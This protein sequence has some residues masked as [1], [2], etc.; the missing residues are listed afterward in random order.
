[1]AK[2]V[3]LAFVIT[4][5]VDFIA[6]LFFIL[7]SP[8]R[9]LS[10]YRSVICIVLLAGV[11]LVLWVAAIFKRFGTGIDSLK[12]FAGNL[13]TGSFLYQDIEYIVLVTL[14]GT[15]VTFV[16]SFYLRRLIYDSQPEISRLQE[17]LMII[18]VLMCAG[19]LCTGFEYADYSKGQLKFSLLHGDGSLVPEGETF[20]TEDFIRLKNTGSNTLDLDDMFLSDKP[21]NLDLLSL[22]GNVIPAGEELTI[23][24]DVTSPFGLGAGETV[25]LSDKSGRVYD[26]A[27]YEPEPEVVYEEPLFSKVSGFYDDEF[28]LTLSYKEEAGGKDETGNAPKIYYTIDGSEPTMESIPYDQPIRIYDRKGEPAPCNMAQR[29]VFDYMYYQPDDQDIDRAFVVK[30]AVFDEAGNRSN[31]ST[32]VYFVGYPGYKNRKVISIT[33][34]YTDLFGD[35]G[36]CVTGPQYDMWYAGGQNGEEPQVNFR[37]SGRLWE[38]EGSIQFFNNGSFIGEQN[39]GIR[40]FGGTSRDFAKKRFSIYSR[41]SYSGSDS[42][43]MDIFGNGRPVHSIALRDGA[44]DAVLQEL[45]SGRDVAS[46]QHTKVSVFLN[47]EFWFNTFA[48]EKYSPAYF[49]EHKGISEDNIIIVKEGLIDTGKPEDEVLY[50][51]IYEYLGEH[52]LADPANYYEFCTMIDVQSY[53][54]YLCATI[55]GCNLDQNEVINRQMYRARTPIEYGENDGRWRWSLYDMDFLDGLFGALDYFEVSNAYEINSFKDRQSDEAV[56]I[57]EQTLFKALMQNAEFRDQFVA[58]FEDMVDTDYS[59]DNVD[60]VLDKYVDDGELKASLRDFFI[61]RPEY[62]KKYLYEEFYTED[63]EGNE[64]TE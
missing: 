46:Q 23:Y 54:D 1:M 24:L 63:T 38:R 33:A 60:R 32:G 13:R 26:S 6:G 51:Q 41:K 35:N 57:E 42:F 7:G 47:G 55:Y 15:V 27:R 59:M 62:M 39:A 5:V 9:K 30:A 44:S 17:N 8:G 21:G 12:E 29:V 52:D 58:S 40:V 37:Q 20:T 36:I 48:C 11:N 2:I 28:M 45:S 53:I 4:L 22:S 61:N 43:E 56:S 50:R 25:Y 64:G 31:S 34:D 10:L 3:L 18:S 49:Y 16:F 14:L 19:L